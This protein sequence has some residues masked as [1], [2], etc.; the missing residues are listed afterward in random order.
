MVSP[1]PFYRPEPCSELAV[2]ESLSFYRIRGQTAASG[3][4]DAA[5]PKGDAQRAETFRVVGSD[6]TDG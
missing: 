4:F 3:F 1:H 6:A 5:P 2:Y